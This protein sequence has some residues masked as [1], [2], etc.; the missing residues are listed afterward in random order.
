MYNLNI[1]QTINEIITET[2][3][4]LDCNLLTQ[5]YIF[6]SFYMILF[7]CIE[8][9]IQQIQCKCMLQLTVFSTFAYVTTTMLLHI[10]LEYITVKLTIKPEKCDS[11]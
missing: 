1:K 6:L 11:N 8:I 5:N 10:P 4:S 9:Q 2:Q 7:V 3:T